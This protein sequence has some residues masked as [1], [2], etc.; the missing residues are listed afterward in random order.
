MWK[1]STWKPLLQVKFNLIFCQNLLILLGPSCCW[2][3]PP[4]IQIKTLQLFLYVI[5]P[6]ALCSDVLS[7]G[8]LGTTP[9]VCVCVWLNHSL[10]FFATRQKLHCIKKQSPVKESHMKCYLL[11]NTIP[12]KNWILP[13]WL[14]A[15][16]FSMETANW[17]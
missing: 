7:T 2:L 8:K 11:S 10:T 5:L 13:T 9:F 12:T 3:C 14:L 16:C 4:V 15:L 17:S 1:V 6:H